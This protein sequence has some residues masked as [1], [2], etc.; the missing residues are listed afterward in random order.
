MNK[1]KGTDPPEETGL[2]KN[3]GWKGIWRMRATRMARA[4]EKWEEKVILKSKDRA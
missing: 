3:T 4:Q 1:D 2:G